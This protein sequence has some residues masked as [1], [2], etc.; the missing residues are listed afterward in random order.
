ML[1]LI[2]ETL[3]IAYFSR[4]KIKKKENFVH[5]FPLAQTK[6]TRARKEEEEEEEIHDEVEV[7][8]EVQVEVEV[9]VEVEEVEEEEEEEEEVE[10]KKHVFR[11]KVW[12]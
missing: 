11:T 8:V 7:E 3:K 10:D 12:S 5:A 4:R 6:V 2:L 9:E 1:I